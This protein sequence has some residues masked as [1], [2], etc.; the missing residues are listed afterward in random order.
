YKLLPPSVDHQAWSAGSC[1]ERNITRAGFCRMMVLVSR[2]VRINKVRLPC[3]LC[4]R[5][6]KEMSEL[7]RCLD[8]RA[9]SQE[10]PHQCPHCGKAFNRSST[11][12][13][14]VRI[15]S[16][17]KPFVC[18]VCGKAFHQLYNLAFHMHTHTDCKPHTCTACGKGFW[19]I[20]LFCCLH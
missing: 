7:S 16:G 15:H 6:R 12:N 8:A 3:F 19:A 2:S 4:S 17:Y 14:H 20:Y 18:E 5:D 1:M 13:M 11:L 10:K 9:C